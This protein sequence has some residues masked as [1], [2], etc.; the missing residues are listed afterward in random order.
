[1]KWIIRLLEPGDHIRVNRGKYY[2][3][4]V[5]V[6]DNEVI[7][8]TGEDG[9]STDKPEL[10]AVR[11]TSID[12][13]AQKGIVE[14]ASPSLKEKFFVRHKN[15]RIRL[16]FASLGKKGYNFFHNNCETFANECCYTRQLTS[17]TEEHQ[18]KL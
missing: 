6:G 3:H 2:H 14:V 12:F 13:V 8:F 15:K 4:G 18:K 10:V 11:K 17:Q 16:A 1:M 7:H 9:D 5:Y